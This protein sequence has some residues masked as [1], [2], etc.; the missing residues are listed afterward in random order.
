M[1]YNHPATKQAMESALETGVLCG[2]EIG[3]HVE[4]AAKITET[5][6]CAETVR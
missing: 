6:P 4:L 2:Y 5:I 1:G 3:A